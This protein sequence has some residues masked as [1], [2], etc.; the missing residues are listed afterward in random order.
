MDTKKPLIDETGERNSVKKFSD[1]LVN[2][3]IIFF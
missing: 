3:L 2:L 1:E